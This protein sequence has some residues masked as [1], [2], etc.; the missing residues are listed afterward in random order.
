MNNLTQVIAA[1]S[2]PPGKGGV[3]IIRMS[4]DGAFEIAEKA[5]L[6][7]SAKRLSDYP[8][9]TQIYGHIIYNEENMK[10][11]LRLRI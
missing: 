4:G 5:F 8:P 10:M 6:P 9:R 1:V 7:I 11:P 2:T 3:A